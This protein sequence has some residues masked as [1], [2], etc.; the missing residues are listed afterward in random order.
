MSSSLSPG[1]S[2]P[3]LG[4]DLGG[5]LPGARSLDCLLVEC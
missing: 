2:K 3:L 5:G 1:I 4:N